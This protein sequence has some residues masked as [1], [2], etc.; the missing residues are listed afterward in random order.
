MTLKILVVGAGGHAH[1]VVDA[2][3]NCTHD[4]QRLLPI[5][6]VDHDAS[7]RGSD[8]QGAPVLGGE[9]AL[10]WTERDGLIV[11]IGDNERRA[12]LFDR[13]S[14]AGENIVSAVHRSATIAE[15]VSIGRGVLVAAG[16]VVNPAAI[17][18]ADCIVNTGA[19]VDHHCV[20]GKH[21]HVAPGVHLGGACTL[22]E[23]AL[24]GIG[25]VVMPGRRVGA[26]AIVGA[27]SV[28]TDDIAPGA[29]VVGC[30]ARSR[31]AAERP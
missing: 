10:E 23:R 19:T 28:V 29:V 9:E 16:A 7:K 1:V 22:E 8:V 20:V 21:V 26:R 12:V 24:I 15:D 14:H 5:G 3:R 6:V 30:P 27:G 11:A 31:S 25:A 2:L 18:E 13:F 4:G 17:L